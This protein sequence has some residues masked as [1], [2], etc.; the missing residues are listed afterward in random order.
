MS[1]L[2]HVTVAISTRLDRLVGELENH[3]AVVEVGIR[4]QRRLYAQAKV[5]HQR[6]HQ[7]GEALRQR[8]AQWQAEEQ[9]WRER[10][11]GC[12]SSSAGEDTALQCL[13]RAREAARQAA[14]LQPAWQQ[15]QAI[16]QRLS[17]EIQDLRERML[18][19]E[20]RRA[21]MRSREASAQARVQVRTAECGVQPDL[22]ETFERWEMRLSETEI[23]AEPT[24][25]LAP[26]P[27]PWPMPSGWPR[28][29]RNSRLSLR[30][31]GA[32]RR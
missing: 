30:H 19:L 25:A 8:L 15:H 20:H 24:A 21:L 12:E 32:H 7:E 5:R 14:A 13:Q 28:N 4:E 22:N 18:R 31:C 2:K 11:L 17:G 29:G 10:A 23:A 6:L 1:L 9:R 27:T 26:R 16:E 3:D